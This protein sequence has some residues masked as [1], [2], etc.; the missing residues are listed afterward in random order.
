MFPTSSRLLL[1]KRKYSGLGHSTRKDDLMFSPVSH[2]KRLD[3]LFIGD[4]PARGKKKK[5]KCEH[6]AVCD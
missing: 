5:K 2:Q 1:G 3:P 4:L 6:Y